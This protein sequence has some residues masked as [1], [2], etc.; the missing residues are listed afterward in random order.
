MK[1]T[2]A[3]RE[4]L[5]EASEGV[6]LRAYPDPGTGGPPWTI[7]FG[8]TALAGPPVVKKGDV[9]TAAQASTILANDLAKFEAGVTALL[10]GMKA[11][12]L[13][14]EF[15]ALVDL[16]FNIGLGNLR[17]SSLLAAYLRGDKATAARKFM[18]WNK[19][20][21]RVMSGL[22]I[23]RARER[24]WFMDGRLGARTTTVGLLTADDLPISRMVD[25]P[26][27][28]LAQ[29]WHGR[30]APKLEGAQ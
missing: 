2:P 16:A 23:R 29:W 7:G 11:P 22:T 19:A 6:R 17:S 9:I 25:H 4:Q 14:R 10:A 20:A 8:H 12:V 15:D 1:M 24:A 30:R 3:A 28:V 18:D 26:D 21:G 27:S 5:T 13:Q